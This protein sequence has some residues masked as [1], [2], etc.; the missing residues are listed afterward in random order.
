MATGSK[1]RIRLSGWQRVGIIASVLWLIIAFI[2][3]AVKTNADLDRAGEIAGQKYNGCLADE[4]AKYEKE[5]QEW[6]RYPTLTV[7]SREY[8]CGGVFEP[9]FNVEYE[10]RR[11]HHFYFVWLITVPLGWLGAYMTRGLWRWVKRGFDPSTSSATRTSENS[12]SQE[13]SRNLL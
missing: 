6:Y 9:V 5:M 12:S 1:R 13:E 2:A 7:P 8:R 11:W 4:A 3:F 10:R